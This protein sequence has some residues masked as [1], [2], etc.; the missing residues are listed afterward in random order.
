MIMK[1]SRRSHRL[2]AALAALTMFVGIAELGAQPNMLQ[3]P[4]DKSAVIVEEVG[5]DQR[6]NAQIPMDATFRDEAGRDVTLRGLVNGRPVILVLAYY[7]CPMLCNEVM[8]GVVRALRVIEFEPAKDFDIVTISIDPNE[9]PKLAA[10]K[11]ASYVKSYGKPSA[12]QGW[13]FLTGSEES[14]KAMT[15]ATG[16]RYVYDPASDQYAH[17]GGIMLLTTEGRISRY[18]YGVEYSPRDLKFGLM[19]ASENEIGSLVEKVLLLCFHYD[20]STGKYGFVVMTVL[21]VAGGLFL[22]AL[23]TFWYRMFRRG[24]RRKFEQGQTQAA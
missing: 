13:H 2:Q 11:K 4:A 19:E 22:L 14:I 9:T 15:S 8:N 5:I 18:F 1:N 7:R 24:R 21:R 16:F 20:P 23:G 3:P 10:E 6:L 17:A 12:N